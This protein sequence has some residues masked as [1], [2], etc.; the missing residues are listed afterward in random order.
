MDVILTRRK[1]SLG[2]DTVEEEQIHVISQFYIEDIGWVYTDPSLDVE[3]LNPTF[4][5]NKPET[6][7]AH[8]GKDNGDFITFDDTQTLV[9]I[10]VYGPTL[11]DPADMTIFFEHKKLETDWTF[12]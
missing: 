10:P 11:L 6:I 1:P 8:F 3:N 2:G 5:I 9:D 12:G 7:L 4:N